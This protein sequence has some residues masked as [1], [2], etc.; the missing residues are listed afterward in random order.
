MKTEQSLPELQTLIWSIYDQ[1][2]EWTPD[3]QLSYHVKDVFWIDGVIP[4]D[5]LYPF[6]TY[7]G[8]VGW[9]TIKDGIIDAEQLDLFFTEDEYFNDHIFV[10][11]MRINNYGLIEI[12][13]G[14]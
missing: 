9:V 13:L 10:E 5:G 8:V 11:G 3:T 14:S 12:M 2:N 7:Y 6:Y 1:S 4:Q